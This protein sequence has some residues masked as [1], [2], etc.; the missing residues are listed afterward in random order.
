MHHDFIDRYSRLESPV[1]SIDARAKIV[2]LFALIIVCVITPPGEWWPFCIYAAMVVVIAA[3]SR[4]P[5]KY[6]L[7]RVLVVLPFILVV[8]VF[9]PFM[10]KGGPSYDVGLFHV[11][12]EGLIILWGVAIKALISVA[13]LILLSATTPFNDLMHGFERLHVPRFFT[14]AAAFMY[15]YI[16]VII[17]EAERMGRAR[18]SR[19]FHGRWLWQAGVVGRMAGTLFLRSHERAER[20][21]DAMSARGFDG[22]FPRWREA[23]MRIS[24]YVFIAIVASAAVAAR[25]VVLWK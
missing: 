10:H 22:T 23:K 12:Q 24:D 19:N 1:Q 16:F 21:F 20:V 5:A 17:D 15:R 13:C 6:L 2:A 25:L 18:D 4:V 8:A 14:T 3:A 7:T 9:V 11:S